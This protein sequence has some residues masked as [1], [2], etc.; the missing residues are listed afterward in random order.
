MISNACRPMLP[1]EPITA[2]RLVR[3]SIGESSYRPEGFIAKESAAMAA[4]Q[5]LA[6]GHAP[7][8]SRFV[9]SLELLRH[10]H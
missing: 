8:R 5:G 2:I 6:S 9:A 1:V 4:M 3:S 7:A 10:G